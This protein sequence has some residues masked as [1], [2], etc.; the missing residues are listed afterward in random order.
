MLLLL[1]LLMMTMPWQCCRTLQ[2]TIFR[3]C[4]FSAITKWIPTH[5]YIPFS[6]LVVFLDPTARRHHRIYTY[7]YIYAPNRAHSE[8]AHTTYYYYY[9]KRPNSS[10]IYIYMY[11]RASSCAS[12]DSSPSS[13]QS[14][15]KPNH[16]HQMQSRHG[17]K[18][19]IIVDRSAAGIHAKEERR[20]RRRRQLCPPPTAA[21]TKTARTYIASFIIHANSVKNIQ[22][23]HIHTNT[24]TYTHTH[25]D[26]NP[27]LCFIY[28][29]PRRWKEHT[30]SRCFFL[31][32][33]F[34]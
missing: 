4:L 2:S 20:R 18:T 24:L 33:R 28:Q 22:S 8:C 34:S 23:L 14:Q 12:R 31:Y 5:I 16:Q 27:H 19:D 30:S 1:V 32:I 9:Y 3:F 10:Y 7:I 21:T 26:T 17:A 15:P 29:G 13:S 25:T 6:P 11:V